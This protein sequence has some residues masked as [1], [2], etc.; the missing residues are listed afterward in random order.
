MLLTVTLSADAEEAPVE[1]YQMYVM[2]VPWPVSSIALLG[3]DTV[4]NLGAFGI[5]APKYFFSV[6]TIIKC[7]EYGLQTIRCIQTY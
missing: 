5:M 6:S 1:E 3:L 7:M 4:Q 2:A